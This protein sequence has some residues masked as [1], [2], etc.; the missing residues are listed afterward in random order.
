MRLVH[1][2]SQT[3]T[4]TCVTVVPR[5]L[6]SML[7]SS[8]ESHP[9]SSILTNM[10]SGM[11]MKD[12]RMQRCTLSVILIQKSVAMMSIT[13]MSEA[14]SSEISVARMSG[15]VAKASVVKERV[16]SVSKEELRSYLEAA[17]PDWPGSFPAFY[18]PHLK[19]SYAVV[20][21]WYLTYSD[22]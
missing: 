10:T 17:K 2:W 12:G 21:V 1:E 4:L 20:L 15:A 5:M 7:G 14:N 22:E 13:K 9:G 11:M 16:S 8:E 18:F 3:W 6:L 19:A